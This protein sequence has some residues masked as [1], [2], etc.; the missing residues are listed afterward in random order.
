MYDY[1][2]V[3]TTVSGLGQKKLSIFHLE[4]LQAGRKLGSEKKFALLLYQFIKLIYIRSSYL[5]AHF[6][7]KHRF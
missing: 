3:Y 7:S 4:S 6:F 1:R 2:K 5:K